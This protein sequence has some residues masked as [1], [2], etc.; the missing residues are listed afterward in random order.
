MCAG[1]THY[2]S[3]ERLRS[4]AESIPQ[5]TIV[6][7]D[8]DHLVA[9]HNSLT[10]HKNMPGSHYVCWEKTGHGVQIQKKIQFNSLLEETFKEGM[11]KVAEH[12]E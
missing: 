2:V 4:I 10:L 7:G 12:N 6:T 9:P 1:L 11:K 5:I 8:T 3:P